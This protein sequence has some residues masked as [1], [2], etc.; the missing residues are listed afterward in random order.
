MKNIFLVLALI[1]FVGCTT[2]E[3]NDKSKCQCEVDI[4][5]KDL[6]FDLGTGVSITKP[7]EIVTIDSG[8]LSCE[9]FFAGNFPSAV[10]FTSSF[11]Y[12]ATESFTVLIVDHPEFTIENARCK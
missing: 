1:V 3:L 4:T 10:T 7:F 5:V 8:E 6:V 12:E 11:E 2:D 9:E